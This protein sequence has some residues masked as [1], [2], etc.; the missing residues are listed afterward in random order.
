MYGLAGAFVILGV[1]A[2][3]LPLSSLLLLAVVLACPLMMMFMMR[4]MHGGGGH[5]GHG[6]HGAPRDR[7]E[8]RGREADRPA[9]SDRLRSDRK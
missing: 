3:G 8:D 9:D 2:F 5:D 6:G 1:A 7:N 4:G